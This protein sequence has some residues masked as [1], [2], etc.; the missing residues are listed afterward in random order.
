M[1]TDNGKSS[2][3]VSNNR[4]MTQAIAQSIVTALQSTTQKAVRPSVEPPQEPSWKEFASTL[5]QLVSSNAELK[6]AVEETMARSARQALAFGD[7][8]L[9]STEE[10]LAMVRRP[11]AM[12]KGGSVVWTDWWGFK[13]R[14]SHEDLEAILNS[15]E[16]L[17]Q[18]L[19]I[20]RRAQN[21]RT[22]GWFYW[23]G[24]FLD[25]ARALLRTLDRGRGVY[26][27]MSWFAPGVFI[28]TLV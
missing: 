24:V 3:D 26:I 2:T 6:K 16:G 1:S 15:T 5:D 28:P 14:V 10:F 18:I 27:S 13:V 17:G 19:E 21:G 11:Q 9:P 23:A 12:G 20:I 4:D 25:G 22:D 7:D 8:A